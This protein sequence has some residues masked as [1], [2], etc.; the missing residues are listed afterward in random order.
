[1]YNVLSIGIFS[2]EY[3]YHVE[4][5]HGVIGPTSNLVSTAIS[6]ILDEA[7][8]LFTFVLFIC[9]YLYTIVILRLS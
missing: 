1:M 6:N 4:G 2:S 9:G 5:V 3:L 7:G 8:E